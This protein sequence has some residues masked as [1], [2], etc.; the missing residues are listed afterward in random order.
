MASEQEAARREREAEQALAGVLL[1]DSKTL[2]SPLE[3]H[4]DEYRDSLE[5]QGRGVAGTQ[6]RGGQG[7]IAEGES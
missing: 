2:L 5:R 7:A 3:T 6:G 4:I 1:V